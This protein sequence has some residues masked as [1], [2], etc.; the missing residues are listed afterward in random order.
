MLF[1][2]VEKS[3]FFL[4][5]LVKEFRFFFFSLEYLEKTSQDERIALTQLAQD[6]IEQKTRAA[7]ERVAMGLDNFT[8]KMLTEN[9][10]M[11]HEVFSSKNF[12]QMKTIVFLFYKNSFVCDKKNSFNSNMLS[13]H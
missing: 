2:R 5:N 4:I 6:K 13:V 7:T 1:F 3:S 10:Y 8:R 12:S 9:Q 11:T